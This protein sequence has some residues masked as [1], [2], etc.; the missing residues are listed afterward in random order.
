MAASRQETWR[1]GGR[2]GPAPHELGPTPL[3][4]AFRAN[5]PALA[6]LALLGFLITLCNLAV[7]A[8]TLEVFNRVATTRSLETLVGITVPFVLACAVGA[9]LA[10]VRASLLRRLGTSIDEAASAPTYDAVYASV[11]A[12]RRIDRLGLLQDL[13]T[14]RRF[15]SGAGV[16]ALLDLPWFVVYV[17]VA[18]AMHVVLGLALLAASGVALILVLASEFASREPLKFATRSG[19]A[20]QGVLD[21]GLR[22]AESVQAM[23]MTGRFRHEWLGLSRGALAWTS[24]AGHAAKTIGV[25]S[26]FWQNFVQYGLIALAAYLSLQ[27]QLS[28]GLM[29]AVMFIGARCVGV[30]RAGA[31]QLPGYVAARQAHARLQSLFRAAEAEAR[32]VALPRPAGDV[33]VEN[34][35][36]APPGA[37]RMILTGISFA[38]P[39]G[40]AVAVVGPSGAGKSTLVR[41]LVGLQPPSLGTVR[42]DGAELA[43][44]DPDELGRHLGYLPQNVDLLAGT[45]AENIA[46]FGPADDAD[47]VAAAEAAGVH[48][49]IQNLPKGYDTRL[50]ES[51]GSLSGGQRQRIGLARAIYGDPALVVLD[52]PNSNLDAAGEAAL[53]GTVE[54]LKARGTTSFII[55][56]KVN[57][58]NLADYILVLKNGTVARFGPRDEIMPGVAG[59]RPVPDPAPEMPR[60]RLAAVGRAG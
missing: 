54:T 16:T 3:D 21:Q 8:F 11:L 43:H 41:A 4:A 23:G 22:E 51:G 6:H 24:K 9:L 19:S 28:P 30:V 53:A 2:S 35:A 31:N 1:P 20:A 48:E 32:R 14:V 55:T 27:G 7:P 52:E 15:W 5:R 57:V 17:G 34:L 12:T 47:V 29:F 45:V 13:E 58:L 10:G 46:R 18:F 60:A 33:A 40:S 56:H 26:K 50:G 37:A 25:L 44:W 36:V 42:L 49:M 38:V 59:P 39:A